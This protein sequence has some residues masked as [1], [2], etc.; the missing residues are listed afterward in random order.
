MVGNLRTGEGPARG[1]A[2]CGGCKNCG[3]E[4]FYF[5]TKKYF[6]MTVQIFWLINSMNLAGASDVVQLSKG[7][8]PGLS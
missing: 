4:L 3:T 1:M 5:G 7:M 2:W 8:A 6:G